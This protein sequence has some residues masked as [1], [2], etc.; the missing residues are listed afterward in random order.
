M[1]R[2]IH[3]V[4]PQSVT[5]IGL[6]TEDNESHPLFDERV[7]SPV[8]ETLVR[9][10]QVY[11]VQQPVIVR[12]IDGVTAV[13]DGR[14]RTR[15]T[16]EAARRAVEAGEVP[17]KLPIC[18]IKADDKR[19]QGIMV[20]TNELRRDDDILVKAAKAQRHLDLVGDIEEVA[21]AF[22][23]TSQ[24]IRQWLSLLEADSRL[25]SAVRAG[26]IA[27]TAAC[28]LAKRPREEQLAVVDKLINGADGDTPVSRAQVKSFIESLSDDNKS[29]PA[30]G[31]P[32][33]PKAAQAKGGQSGITRGWLRKALKTQAASGL[34]SGQRGVL[35]WFATGESAKGTWFDQFQWD[36]QSEMDGNNGKPRKKA[37][38]AATK[39][40]DEPADLPPAEPADLPDVED[41]ADFPD[42]EDAADIPPSEESTTDDWADLFEDDDSEDNF[43]EDDDLEDD[44]DEEEEA[45]IADFE[46]SLSYDFGS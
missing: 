46:K 29:E 39:P 10:I 36:A 16:R 13:V 15:A 38:K 25:H 30:A 3:Y 31:K 24:T 19:V 5:I 20:S 18:S 23:R 9:N 17:P 1:S 37:S 14:Q 4:D 45:L 12:E 22:G 8:E 7:F 11:G 33:T 42:A 21:I 43:D 28:D 35:E 32:K 40:K 41:A 2:E 26:K 6:D 34:T 44:F 27:A